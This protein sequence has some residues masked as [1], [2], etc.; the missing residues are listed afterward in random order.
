MNTSHDEHDPEISALYRKTGNV[1]PPTKLDVAV[2]AT[3]R[4]AIRQRRQRWILPLST[5][6]VL[7]L[8][9]TVLLK[10]NSEWLPTDS[11]PMA[12]NHEETETSA[13]MLEKKTAPISPEPQALR[14]MPPQQAAR[15]KKEITESLDF[16]AD[17]APMSDSTMQEAEKPVI[18][19]SA[20]TEQ[21]VLEPKPWIE[22]IYKLIEEKKADD[23]KKEL[24]AF[25]KRYPDYKLPADLTSLMPAG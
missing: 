7:M 20:Q 19:G 24:D 2:L 11:V 9:I 23:A 18:A 10:I 22:K 6:A 16:S 5:A 15:A 25:R 21:K 12:I 8:G 14:A 17:S 13:G 1:E 3:A 4:R